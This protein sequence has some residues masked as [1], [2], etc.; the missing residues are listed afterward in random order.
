[1]SPLEVRR[2]GGRQAPGEC[3]LSKRDGQLY[4]EHA[5]P[6]VWLS[7]EFLRNLVGPGHINEWV[8]LTYQPR[9]LCQPA[10]CCQR[11]RGGHCYYGAIITIRGANET[12]MYRVGGYL[13]GGFW[14]AEHAD[15]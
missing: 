2:D 12:V 5:D 7:D 11:F 10:R 8:S 1:M 6:K 13:R 3:R 9:D 14:E 15:K 4:I